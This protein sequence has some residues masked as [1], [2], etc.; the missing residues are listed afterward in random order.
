MG[1]SRSAAAT[2][3]LRECAPCGEADHRLADCEALHARTDVRDDA[4]ELA[5]E[6]QWQQRLELLLVLNDQRVGVVDA[7]GLDL[8]DNLSRA[9]CGRRAFLD[10]EFGGRPEAVATLG[11]QAAIASN[12]RWAS[13]MAR[14]PTSAASSA[15][16]LPRAARAEMPSKITAQRISAKA[17]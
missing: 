17:Q 6:C 13:A 12:P 11:P 16:A 14:A 3:S 2:A 9:G 15:T 8:D 5:S 10:R 4:G 7:R 1:K